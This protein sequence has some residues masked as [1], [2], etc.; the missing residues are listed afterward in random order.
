VDDEQVEA[1]GDG[2]Y[3]L[4]RDETIA[5]EAKTVDETMAAP[6]P[7]IETAEP[8]TE[9]RE[10]RKETPILGESPS[11]TYVYS[12]RLKAMISREERHS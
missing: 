5:A 3:G 8:S 1:L 7:S 12:H 4:P 2:L 9:A 6:E 11:G 10:S